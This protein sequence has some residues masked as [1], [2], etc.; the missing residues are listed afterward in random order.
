M[1]TRLLII[2]LLILGSTWLAPRPS[3]AQVALPQNLPRTQEPLTASEKWVL[4]RLGLGETADLNTLAAAKP[5]QEDA[6]VL[7]GA[8][9]EALLNDDFP[10]FK[11]HWHGVQIR[12]ATIKGKVDLEGGEIPFGVKLYSCLFTDRVILKESRF[13]RS[14]WIFRSTFAHDVDGLRI[15]IDKNCY[16]NGC[17]FQ[18]TLNLAWGRIGKEFSLMGASFLNSMEAK[19]EGLEVGSNAIAHGAVF[20]GPVNFFRAAV[21][22]NLECNDAAFS[23]N[24]NFSEIKVNGNLGSHRALFVS[25]ASFSRA[26]VGKGFLATDLTFTDKEKFA[27]FPEMRIGH[28]ANLQGSHFAGPVDLNGVIVGDAL[29]ADRVVFGNELHANGLTVQN[30]VSLKETVCQGPVSLA[31][32]EIGGQINAYRARFEHADGLLATG[33]KVGQ[34]VKV[35]QAFF[36]GP[37]HFTGVKIG[38]QLRADAQE[39]EKGTLFEEVIFL[40]E[41]SLQD[42]QL[43]DLLM[44]GTPERLLGISRLNLDRVLVNRDCR[45]QDVAIGA[46]NA[47]RFTGKGETVLQ[48]V[49]VTDKANFLDSSFAALQI[50]QTTW[51]TTPDGLD[52]SGL[53]FQSIT[54]ESVAN[55]LAWLNQAVFDTRN[56]KNYQTYLERIGRGDWADAVFISMKRRE[57]GVDTWQ[58]R[59]NPLKWPLLL[60]W[61]WPVGY[62]RKPQSIFWFALPFILLGAI[63]LDPRYLQGIQWPQKNLFCNLA[64]R[65]LL[66]VDKFTPKLLEFGLEDKWQPPHLSGFQQF[67]LYAHKLMGKV[68][69]SIFFIAVYAR[70]R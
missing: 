64:G 17:I 4:A 23:K 32:A 59:L 42:A 25:G 15:E 3:S 9:L 37:L 8:F 40:K 53:A 33:M 67:F 58:Q 46:F 38:G 44:R 57:W 31:D 2:S 54:G 43:S 63:I 62:G 6:A 16:L 7:R 48:N 22:A 24:V 51:P 41:V 68:F 10:N 30:I 34:L 19:F 28:V 27:S 36:A 65:L 18:G 49:R 26:T 66:S 13:K 47:R 60:C 14:L 45:L 5:H 50:N 1:R 39:V 70:F 35:S 56:Y 21:G 55:V 61:D 52:V 20:S 29:I 11:I 69:L 12:N